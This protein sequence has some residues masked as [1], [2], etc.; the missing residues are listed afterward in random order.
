MLCALPSEDENGRVGS[1]SEENGDAVLGV[2]GAE[3]GEDAML[4][5]GEVAFPRHSP[6]PR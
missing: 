5:G 2:P 3:S 4:D 6:S 1:S